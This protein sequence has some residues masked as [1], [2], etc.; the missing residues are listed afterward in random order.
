MGLSG[1]CRDY[2]LALEFLVKQ[3]LLAHTS[4]RFLVSVRLS[5]PRIKLFVPECRPQRLAQIE[6]RQLLVSVS[7]L[8]QNL[9]LSLTV[10]LPVSGTGKY[11]SAGST[12]IQRSVEDL[13]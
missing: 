6:E 10:E 7:G 1:Q 12:I 5:F 11:K 8:V 2:D 9:L 13:P 3:I 4:F